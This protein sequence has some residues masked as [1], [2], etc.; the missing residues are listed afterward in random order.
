MCFGVIFRMWV[1]R[2]FMNLWLCEIKISVF[3]YSF[4]VMFSDLMDFIF[5]WLVGLFMIRMF[6]FCIIN[7]LNSI[8]FFFLLES[9][10]VGFLMLFWLNSKWLRMLCIVCLLLFFCFYW[11]IYLNMVRLFLNL[12][13]WFWV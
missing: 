10:L 4:S 3:W 11:F 5:R 8:C 2:E 6:G 7:L 12:Y 13:L 9:I 1:V